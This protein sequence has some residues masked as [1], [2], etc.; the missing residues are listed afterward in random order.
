MSR[1]GKQP[2]VIPAG[3]EASMNGRT[4]TLKGSKGEDS[5]TIPD[6]VDVKI[7]DGQAVVSPS[8]NSKQSRS[9]YGT[10]RSLIAN[11]VEGVANGYLK[12]LELEGVGFRAELKGAELVLALG[13]SHPIHFKVPEGIT[14][15]VTQNTAIAV[16]GVSKQLVG[17]SAAQIRS[18]YPAEPYKGKGVRYKGEQIRR[19][20]GKAV[21]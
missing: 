9:M 20:A 2:V 14:I 16:S 21:A 10:V 7:E 19:K 6:V 5:Y 4:I 13:Y 11:M 18:Y 15:V 1:I 12:E 3:V 17:Q 8:S